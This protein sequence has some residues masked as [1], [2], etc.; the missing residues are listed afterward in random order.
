MCRRGVVL[1][2]EDAGG[3]TPCLGLGLFGLGLGNQ[4]QGHGLDNQVLD[5]NTYSYFS[6]FFCIFEFFSERYSFG[7]PS[8]L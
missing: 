8:V 1:G 4:V 7:F 2:L 3:Q 6:F 5:V